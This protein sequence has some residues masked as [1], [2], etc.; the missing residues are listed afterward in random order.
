[1]LNDWKSALISTFLSVVV[2]I[3][4]TALSWSYKVGQFETE[5]RQLQSQQL[6]NREL[7]N[8]L[9]QMN[10]NLVIIQ[11]EMKYYRRDIDDL[12]KKQDEISTRL[13]G[14]SAGPIY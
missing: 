14:F 7:V 10:E 3:G 4:G 12:R 1:M 5:V 6:E 9:R 8:Q 13:G 2:A 11:T